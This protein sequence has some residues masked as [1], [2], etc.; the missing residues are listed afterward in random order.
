MKKEIRNQDEYTREF[1]KLMRESY[2]IDIDQGF[3]KKIHIISR[4]SYLYGVDVN[5]AVESFAEKFG[6]IKRR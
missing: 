2:E 4:Q 6:L 5:E 1:S 3:N